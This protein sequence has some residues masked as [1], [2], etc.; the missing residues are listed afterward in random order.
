MNKALKLMLFVSAMFTLADEAF[1][2]LYA[3]FVSD[4]G[5]G[6]LTAGQAYAVFGIS[7]GILIFIISRWEDR[8]NHK[9]KL[10]VVGYGIKVLG[11]ALLLAVAKPVHFFAVQAVLGIG[12]AVAVPAYDST[13]SKLLD[14]GKFAREWGMWEATWYITAAV[15]GLVGAFVAQKFGFP[16][17]FVFMVAV[18]SIGFFA[19]LGL[20]REARKEEMT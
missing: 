1:L 8:V 19:S 14:Q 3:M 11:F 9:E 7:C 6:L 12:E 20:L 18:S 2:P 16:A 15:A 5:G 13:Y 10:V 17:L 4:I